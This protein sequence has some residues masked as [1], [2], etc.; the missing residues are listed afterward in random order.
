M[1][2][3]TTDID[4]SSQVAIVTGGGRGLGKGMGQALATAGAAVALVGRS[5]AHVKEAADLIRQS[6]GRALALTADVSDSMAVEQMAQKVERELGPV[7]LLVNNA[8]VVGTPSPIWEND[9]EEFRRVMDTNV[10][11]AFLCARFILPAMVQ[12]RR[13]RIINVASGAALG[14][15]PYG[16]SYC[17]SKAALLRLT[18]C[19][20]ADTHEHG[21]SVFAIDPGTVRTD[22]TNYLTDSEA[23]QTYAPWFRKFVLEEHGDVPAE[24][25][26]RLVTLLASGAADQ[27][28]GRMIT[29]TDDVANLV[30]HAEQI[31]GNDLYTL[32]LQRLPSET[33]FN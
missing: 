29:V 17:V 33:E 19:M 23:G 8:G 25:S 32:R 21:I 1:S 14:P 9:P 16:H 6:G 18:E 30:K 10:Y 28:S 15:I 11:G 22:M 3:D 12:R 7:D 4:L 13:G 26:A 5:E 2:I 20:A 24:L 27:L 31:Q